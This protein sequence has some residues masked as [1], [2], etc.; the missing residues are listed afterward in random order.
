[1]NNSAKV[2]LVT[3]GARRIGAAICRELHNHGFHVIIHY[4]Q[5]EEEAQTLAQAFNQKRE[6]SA[7]TRQADL[8]DFNSL[9][10]FAAQL[11]SDWGRLDLLVNNA[12]KFLPSPLADLDHAQWEQ[13]INSNLKGAVFLTQM[14]APLLKASQGSIVNLLDMQLQQPL[15]HYALYA[16]AKAGLHMFTRSSAL[17]LAPD[18]RVNGIAPGIILWPEDGY[19][20][21]QTM[22]QGR[23]AKIP[24]NRLGDPK[25][26][27]ETVLFLAQGPRYIT[28]EI[29]TV[30]GGLSLV[31][32]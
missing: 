28:G 14:L 13:L 19:Y 17:E 6:H 21:N 32:A 8:K 26:I 23:L 20:D 30:D 2:A 24:C 25:E 15:Q 3:G 27:A 18:I 29:I 1:M 11:V 31:S 16:I 10:A 4:N 5:S 9:Q 7:S 12:A 22:K